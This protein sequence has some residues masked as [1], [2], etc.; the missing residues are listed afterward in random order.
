MQFL[1]TIIFFI[2]QYTF[3]LYSKSELN[4]LI[5]LLAFSI[6]IYSLRINKDFKNFLKFLT[7]K[8]K[9]YLITLTF[10]I[11]AALATSL[12]NDIAIM[13][14]FPFLLLYPL[15]EKE[16]FFLGVYLTI[17]IN[18]ISSLTAIGNPQNMFLANKFR[19]T[20]FSFLKYSIKPVT[21]WVITFAI[22]FK[23]IN[24]ILKIDFNKKLNLSNNTIKFNFKNFTLN[25]VAFIL[26]L[27]IWQFFNVKIA[28][29]TLIIF[30]LLY[31]IFYKKEKYLW[32]IDINIFFIFAITFPIV[33]F[34]SSILTKFQFLFKNSIFFILTSQ[35]ISNVPT[36]I[37]ASKFIHN[38]KTIFSLANLSGLGTLVA[39][40]ANLLAFS[41]LRKINYPN[42]IFI[43]TS[44]NFLFLIIIFM[45]N[46]LI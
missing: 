13:L 25:L 18:L 8:F 37:I 9:N 5:L 40:L 6:F 33:N 27:A 34:L 7:C 17:F 28:S 30:S 11:A 3:H 45:I 42:K 22:L 21:I 1:L 12:T 44:L 35:I 38:F 20:F 23:I 4:T 32:K 41:F 15:K 19:L 24:K 39:S 36:T 16:K 10:I 31:F 43:F 14:I 29:I 46:R 26:F 2:L